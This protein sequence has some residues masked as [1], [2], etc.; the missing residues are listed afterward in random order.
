MDDG[1]EGQPEAPL[2][3]GCHCGQVRYTLRG[4][5]GFQFFCQCRDCQKLSGGGYSA[6]LVFPAG[7]LTVQGETASY[8][9]PG[10]SGNPVTQVFCPRCASPL[11]GTVAGKEI[12]LLRAGSLDAPGAFAPAKVLFAERAPD[13]AA[14]HLPEAD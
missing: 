10:G 1:M 8:A 2:G 13:W 14:L 12:I 3:G 9:Y 7:S 5:P 6:N 11:Y 4:E